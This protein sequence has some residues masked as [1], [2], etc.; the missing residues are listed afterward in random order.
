MFDLHNRARRRHS[1]HFAS[2]SACSHIRAS[3]FPNPAKSI[4]YFQRR[5]ARDKKL[6]ADRNTCSGR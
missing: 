1:A 3:L 4:A 2:L 6:S 5:R